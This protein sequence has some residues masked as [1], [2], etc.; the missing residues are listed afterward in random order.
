MLIYKASIALA[1][2]S[3][4]RPLQ[5]LPSFP[6]E[7]GIYRQTQLEKAIVC[8]RYCRS[9]KLCK[10]LALRKTY[11]DNR[12]DVRGN[13]DSGTLQPVIVIAGLV[14]NTQNDASYL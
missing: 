12:V 2:I 3:T 11:L 4:T 10:G 5:N 1:S 14:R 6:A 7:A 9:D 8:T 13:V